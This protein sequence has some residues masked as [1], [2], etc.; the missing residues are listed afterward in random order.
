MSLINTRI[1]NIIAKGNLDK[2]ERRPSA[3]GALDTFMKQSQDGAGIITQDLKEKALAA[4][5]TTL[6]VPVIDYDGDVTIGNVLSATIADDENVSKKLQITFATYSWGF[7]VVPSLFM[8]NEIKMQ[9]DFAAKFEK[10]LYKFAGTLE[11]V[12]VAALSA[13]K[14]QVLTDPL[15]YT[16]A[17]NMINGTWAQRETLIGDIDPMMFANDFFG[18]I[19]VIGN[20]GIQSIINKLAQ[21]GVYND[22]NLRMEYAGKELHWSNLIA[23]A[24]GKFGTGYAVQKGTIGLLTKFE[25]EALL[26][27]KARTGHEWDIE[28]LPML[29][30][31]VGTY[32]YESVGDFSAI[33]GAASSDMKRVMKEHYGFAVDVAFVTAYNSDPATLASPIIAFDI[34]KSV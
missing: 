31:P 8:N 21:S 4:V 27:T 10:Y 26:R 1:Q 29:N 6:E 20:T 24:V 9:E 28:T 7:T 17:A 5:N 12:A 19:D 32:Y 25:R 18:E 33:G 30:M 2:F 22:K 3:Y 14:T 11:G 13:A 34:A 15:D 16:F 23:N